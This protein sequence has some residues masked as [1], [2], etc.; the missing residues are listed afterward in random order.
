MKTNARFQKR[1]WSIFSGVNTP[2]RTPS[3]GPQ[4]EDNRNR[5]YANIDLEVALISRR[6]KSQSTPSVG[7]TSEFQPAEADERSLFLCRHHGNHPVKGCWR[8][9][10]KA[11]KDTDKGQNTR[12]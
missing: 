9:R 7:V 2:S 12:R 1:R 10:H 6:G 4:L 8:Q 5:S 11:V 3:V